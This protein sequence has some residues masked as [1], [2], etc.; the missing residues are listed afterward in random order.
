MNKRPVILHMGTKPNKN[1]ERVLEALN[2]MN[3]LL[4]I[5]GKLT[6]RQSQILKDYRIDYENYFDV[7]Y[8]EIVQYYQN[9]I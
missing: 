8:A 2:K 3:C 1:L 5:V 9:V 6:S 4:I 7:D